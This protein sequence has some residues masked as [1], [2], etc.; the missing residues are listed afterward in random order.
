MIG[1]AVAVGLL[2]VAGGRPTL[3]AQPVVAG[4]AVQC[5]FSVSVDMNTATT[6]E[7]VAL[8]AGQRIHVCGFVLQGAGATTGRLVSGTGTNCAANTT[9][10]TGP[11]TFTTTPSSVP[12]GS[13]SGTVIRT[14][15]GHALC[16]TNT[17]SVQLSGVITYNRF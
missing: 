3:L 9:N 14:P 1:L 17:G 4:A 16:V 11:F 15:L 8:A 12:Y 13:G 5:P 10:L 2:A 7:R 6:A